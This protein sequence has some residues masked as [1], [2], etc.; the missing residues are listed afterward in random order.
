MVAELLASDLGKEH[1]GLPKLVL[2]WKRRGQ[3]FRGQSATMSE[4]FGGI[5]NSGGISNQLASLV[6]SF[7]PSRDDLQVYQQKVQLVLSVWP[8]NRISELVTRLILNTTGS[9]LCKT[10]D[11]PF[12]VEQQRGEVRAETH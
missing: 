2:D 4:S 3:C 1:P 6:P 5:D 7:D 10:P 12:G 8:T 11:T 9:G